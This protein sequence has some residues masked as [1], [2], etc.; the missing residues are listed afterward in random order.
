[1]SNQFINRKFLFH[2]STFTIY[3]KHAPIRAFVG[4]I[5]QKNLPN[6]VQALCKLTFEIR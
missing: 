1:M 4:D 2:N 5:P 3:H 6:L